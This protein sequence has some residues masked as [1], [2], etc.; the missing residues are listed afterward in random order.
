MKNKVIDGFKRDFNLIKSKGWIESHRA[1]DTGIGKTFEDLIGIVENNNY[2]ADYHDI[3]ELKASRNLSQSLVTLFTKAP[4]PRGVN[5]IIRERFGQLDEG[6]KTIH[7]TFSAL[8]FNNFVNKY[9][10]KIEI[11]ETKKRLYVLVK[12]LNTSKIEDI[13]IYYDFDD[14]KEIIENKCK[15]IAYIK[16]QSKK[17]Q[18]LNIS[19]LKKLFY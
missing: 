19:N 5:K 11:D 8:K 1:H 16:T 13:N 3:L 17:K 15:Y 2:L 12:D 6:L 18:V 10:F 14:I 7:T 4:K 9:G